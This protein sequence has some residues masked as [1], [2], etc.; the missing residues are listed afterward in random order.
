LPKLEET[1]I[2]KA[3]PE[4]PG[5]RL[6]TSVS[7]SGE[8]L[9]SDPNAECLGF[10]DELL[11]DRV[12]DRCLIPGLTPSHPFQNAF[13]PLTP[14]PLVLLAGRHPPFAVAFGGRPAE[15]LT[16][17]IGRNLD[18]AK[19]DA[20]ELG[21]SPWIRRDFLDLN[22]QE[23]PTVSLH[24]GRARWHLPSHR[25]PLELSELAVDSVSSMQ[26]LKTECP[27]RFSKVE[28]SLIITDAGGLESGDV[29]HGGNTTNG[30]YREIGGQPEQFPSFPVGQFVESQV[31][32]GLSFRSANDKVIA[33]SRK[34]QKDSIEFHHLRRG[35]DQFATDGANG[36]HLN[37]LLVFDVLLDNGQWCA[38]NCGD[39]VG[40]GPERRQSTAKDREFQSEEPGRTA[41]DQLDQSMDSELWIDFDQKMDVIGHHLHLDQL[42]SQ[43]NDLLPNQRL[44]SLVDTV[45]QH[46]AAVFGAKYDVVLARVHHV[47]VALQVHCHSIY[48]GGA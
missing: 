9:Q 10:A 24:Q 31:S 17:R 42:A 20:K 13:S 12:V 6:L 19:I 2:T 11:A 1:P 22:M 8:V 43:F 16:A 33:R 44:E 18:D 26:E 21:N 5:S 7:Q 39:E 28:D 34:G 47:L 27:V 45:D 37:V 35:G 30:P 40:V 25:L 14:L 29:F 15:C 38:P 46:F 4:S 41:L 32:L 36:F 23:V 3:T 48:I